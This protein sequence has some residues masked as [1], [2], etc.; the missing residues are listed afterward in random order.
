MVVLVLIAAIV[1]V[2]DS[3]DGQVPNL[4]QTLIRG[5]YLIATGTILVYASAHREH[6]RN[7]LTNLAHSPLAVSGRNLSLALAQV[8]KQAVQVIEASRALVVW[9]EDDGGFRAAIWREGEC[10]IVASDEGQ[11]PPV[12][13]TPSW[14]GW[15]FR[16]RYPT[17]I[18]SIFRTARPA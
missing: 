2:V 5:G 1:A 4:H 10:E 11:Y 12:S 16:G 14:R 17:L 6:E 3:A 13:V 18:G 7:R 15:H 8:L 9:E